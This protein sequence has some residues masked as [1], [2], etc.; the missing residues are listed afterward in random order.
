[1]IRSEVPVLLFGIPFV[2]NI[3]KQ[4]PALTKMV[5]RGDSGRLRWTV[6]YRKRAGTA[7]D[8]AEENARTVKEYEA[9]EGDAAFGEEDAASDGEHEA[10]VAA[11]RTKEKPERT[12]SQPK[13]AVGKAAKP[14]PEG[15]DVFDEDTNDPA[16]CRAIESC[17][18]EITALS[19]HWHPSIAAQ[20]TAFSTKWVSQRKQ[21]DVRS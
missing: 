17:L 18:W 10:A 7:A 4:H 16:A 11:A 5:H 9:A 19:S 6:P 20:S 15:V 14:N 1:M 12:T 3:L 2:F 13:P 21:V 8:Y